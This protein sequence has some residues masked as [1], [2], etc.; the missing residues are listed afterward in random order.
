MNR[1]E[2]AK[3]LL[4][5]I[6]TVDHNDSKSLLDLN[7]RGYCIFSG[8][9]YEKVVRKGNIK[10]CLTE[11]YSRSRD[12]LKKAR[13]EG[14]MI[15]VSGGWIGSDCEEIY[16]A[17]AYRGGAMTLESPEL[18]TEELAEFHAIIQAWIY[19]WDNE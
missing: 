12:A 3:D 13:P 16:D 17:S 9:G 4:K 18:P 19:I 8:L 7:S 6:E 15:N 14:W 11:D 1:I 2:A 10:Y 5:M